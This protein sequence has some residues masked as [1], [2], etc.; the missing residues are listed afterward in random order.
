MDNCPD[1]QPSHKKKNPATTILPW[2]LVVNGAS[3]F[4]TD[5]LSWFGLS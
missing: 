2:I 1:D 3:E 4:V 5:A